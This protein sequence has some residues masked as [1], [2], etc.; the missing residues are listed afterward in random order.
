MRVLRPG[1]DTE[2]FYRRVRGAP[3]RVLLLDYDGTLAPFREE[4]DRAV[5][6]PGVAEVLR[7]ILDA[8]H[9]HLVI[10]SGRAVEDVRLLLGIEPPPQIWGNHGWEHLDVEGRLVRHPLSVDVERALERAGTTLAGPRLSGR[11][12]VKPASVAVHLRGL[13]NGVAQEVVQR[14]RTAWQPLASDARLE[15]HEFD[16][17]L[18]LRPV[19]RDKGSAVVEALADVP[20]DAAS[21]YLGDDRTDEDAFRAMVGRG[22]SVLVRPKPRETLADVW[23][24]PPEELLAFLRRWEHEAPPQERDSDPSAFSSA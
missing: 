19:G 9:T 21:A 17:G 15:I 2:A 3:A 6:Y 12:E 22:L 10:V 1:V 14:V 11:V 24:R 8:G 7:Q 18:E 16:G 13:S 5:P 4:R 23:I 20:A